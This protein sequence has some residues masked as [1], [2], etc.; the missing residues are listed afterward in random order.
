MRKLTK[1]FL[2]IASMSAL[3]ACGGDK[4]AAQQPGGMPAALVQV[5]EVKKGDHP[6]SYSFPGSVQGDEYVEVRS[7]AT[8]ILLNIAY[9]E[10]SFVEKGQLLFEIDPAVYEAQVAAATGSL[11]QAN[12]ALN[13][14]QH[15]FDRINALYKKDAVSES[16]YDNALAGLNTA[17]A[18]KASATANLQNAEIMLSYTKITAPFSGYTGKSVVSEGNLVS[19]GVALTP[20][21]KIDPINVNFSISNSDYEVIRSLTAR[22]M[23]DRNG[24]AKAYNSKGQLILDNGTMEYIEQFMNAATGSVGA[25]AIFA[26]TNTAVLPG[27]FVTISTGNM[28]LIDSILIPQKAVLQTQMGQVVIV[29]DKDNI[30]QFRPVKLGPVFGNDFLIEGGL[31]EGE[32]IIIEG[33]NKVRPNSE[34]RIAEPKAPAQ[35]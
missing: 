18:A 3:A 33:N 26:N 12:A 27:E 4:Q 22:G 8:G 5:Q 19:A 31:A 14:A 7:Q 23:L 35:Q 11:E 25:R 28:N 2:I 15:T 21:Y 17:K 29:V 13:N 6:V 9:V 24:V 10:G 30:A 16:D 20:L 1:L 34:V 32:R